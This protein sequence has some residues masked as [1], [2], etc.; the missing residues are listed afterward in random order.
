MRCIVLA[1][2][3]KALKGGNP[4]MFMSVNSFVNHSLPEE[5]IESFSLTFK[6]LKR[7][8]EPVSMVVK[9]MCIRQGMVYLNLN[10]PAKFGIFY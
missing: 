6:A 2:K 8:D 10:F 3:M 4:I 1:M 5:F 9:K 7:I